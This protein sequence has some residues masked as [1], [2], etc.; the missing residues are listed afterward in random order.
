MSLYDPD[1]RTW[2]FERVRSAGRAWEPCGEPSIVFASPR[3]GHVT[4]D[5]QANSAFPSQKYA[6]QILH[7]IRAHPEVQPAASLL[8]ALLRVSDTV[9]QTA[10]RHDPVKGR[11]LDFGRIYTSNRK[12]ER[13]AAFPCGPAGA[14]LRIVRVKNQATGWKDSRNA[15]VDVPLPRAEEV[16]LPGAGAPIQQVVFAHSVEQRDDFLAVRELTRTVVYKPLMRKAPRK[17]SP[18][19]RLDGNPVFTLPWASDGKLPHADVA[20]NHWY[21]RQFGVV[22]QAGFWAVWELEGHAITS[23]K[24]IGRGQVCEAT[25]ED[26]RPKDDGWARLTWVRDPGIVAVCTRR[27]LV[28]STVSSEHAAQTIE[29]TSDTKERWILDI[30]GLPSHLEDL[31]VLTSTHV[32]VYCISAGYNAAPSAKLVASR[33]HYKSPEDTTLRLD[34]EEIFGELSLIIKSDLDPVIAM[35]QVTIE[36]DGGVQLLDALRFPLAPNLGGAV[37]LDLHITEANVSGKLQWDHG[38]SLVLEYQRQGLRFASVTIL[39]KDLSLIQCLYVTSDA[40]EMLTGIEAPLWHGNLPPTSTKAPKET[41]VVGEDDAEFDG[42]M[43]Q[44]RPLSL[45]APRRRLQKRSR[46]GIDW[47]VPLE[48]LSRALESSTSL[49]HLDGVM[50]AAESL[51]QQQSDGIR[52]MQTLH[53][54]VKGEL[55]FNDVQDASERLRDL[56]LSTVDATRPRENIDD[57]SHEPPDHATTTRLA[58]KS[59]SRLPY[60]ASEEAEGSLEPQGTYDRL[61]KDWVT[62][63]PARVSGRV[64]L[65]KEQLVRRAAAELFLA[66]FRINVEDVPQP[67]EP[68]SQQTQAFQSPVNSGALVSSQLPPSSPGPPWSSQLLSSQPPVLPTPSATPS[69]ATGSSYPSSYAPTEVM[70]LSRYTTFSTPPTTGLPRSLNRVLSHWTVGTNPSDYDWLRTTRHISQ[71]EDYFN[72]EMTEKERARVQRRAERHLRR[73]R[74]E[75]AASQAAQLA[76]SQAPAIQLSANQPHQAPQTASQPTIIA[77]SS[78]SQG[79]GIPAASQVVPGRFGGRP[80]KKKRKQGF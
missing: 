24:C 12:Y 40:V 22:D 13:V 50:D 29:V 42:L 73:Q 59:I 33:R 76:S 6:K 35:F 3:E 20:F 67:A 49:E 16:V 55:L 1:E 8:P 65:A 72:E 2:R 31:C 43:D 68:E 79:F 15:W 70:R 80:P 17:P 28:L 34:I 58:L 63:L 7:V 30:A 26:P 25:W 45:R 44:F 77:D 60:E 4:K 39:G 74:R 38:D 23:A 41:F 5:S 53:D 10:K 37:V 71:Q 64:R 78:Q 47:T 27:D 66:S 36:D 46:D 51:F 18:A 9:E 14:D 56:G 52:P 61:L 54:M 57:D 19:S 48:E 75:A 32:L 11:L 69:I 21:P 62:P